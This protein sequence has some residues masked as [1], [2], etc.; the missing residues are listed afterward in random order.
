MAYRPSVARRAI[1]DAA[2]RPAA[3]V[4]AMTADLIAN[5]ANSLAFQSPREMRSTSAM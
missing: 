1:A 4:P 5:P 3:L 2:A